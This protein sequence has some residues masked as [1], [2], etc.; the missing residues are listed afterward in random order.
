VKAVFDRKE[1]KCERSASIRNSIAATLARRFGWALGK[2]RRREV[3]MTTSSDKDMPLDVPPEQRRTADLIKRIRKLRWIGMEP[4]AA[5][6]QR[7][8]ACFPPSRQAIMRPTL[9]ERD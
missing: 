7:A 8:M 3:F 9:R 4:E 6:L 1:L 5:N 2:N